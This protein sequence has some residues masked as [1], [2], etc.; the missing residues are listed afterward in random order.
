MVS[1][2]KKNPPLGAMDELYDTAFVSPY[3]YYFEYRGI[4]SLSFDYNEKEF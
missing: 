3:Q 2:K 1:D 4:L